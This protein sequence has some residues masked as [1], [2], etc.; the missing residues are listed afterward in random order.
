M[1]QH[2]TLA[3]RLRIDVYFCDAHS[4]WQGGTNEKAKGLIREYLPK[5]LNAV[6]DDELAAIE[7]ALNNGTRKFLDYQTPTEVFAALKRDHIAGVAL[8]P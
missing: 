7:N 4:P 5:A 1:A 6:C 3:K 8:Q 2:A